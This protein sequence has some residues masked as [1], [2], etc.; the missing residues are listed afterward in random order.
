MRSE[1]FWAW[2]EEE[3]RPKLA[4]RR[5]T[6]AK[7]FEHLDGIDRPV[8][9]FETGCIEEPDNWA[10]N[11][12]STILF[13]RYI[14]ERGDGSRLFSVELIASK[15]EAAKAVVPNATMICGDSV[16][17]L[18]DAMRS[19]MTIDLLYLDA[20]HQYWDD[21]LP[22]AIHHH[23]ELMAAM[24]AIQRETMVVVDDSPARV[25]N[26][27]PRID[28]IGKG[29]LVAEHMML[30]GAE[31]AFCQYQA[32]WTNVTSLPA[33][34]GD[35]D[36]AALVERARRHVETNNP[37]A[38]ESLYRL[39]LG[40][41]TPPKSGQTRVAYGEACAFY[42][43]IALGRQRLGGAADWLREALS[44][45]PLGTDYRIDLV[46]RCFIPMGNL[47]T[48]RT[49][50]ERATKISPDHP[51]AWKILGNVHHELGNARDAIEAYDKQIALLPGDADAL[52][53]RATIA[54]DVEDY[55]KVRDCCALVMGAESERTPDATHCLA[56]VAY[57]E[58]R[59]EDA[60]A[61]FDQAIA[62]GCRDPGA[63]AWNKSLALHSI[64]RYIEGWAAHEEREHTRQNPALYLPMTRFT[65]P[66]WKGQPPAIERSTDIRAPQG[67]A[68]IHVHAEAG[69][70]DNLSLCRYLRPMVQL[71]YR[72]RYEA[73]DDMVDLIRGSFPEVEVMPRAADYPGALG[74]KPFDYH[75]PIGSL[76][77]VMKTDID[78]IPWDGPYLKADPI[79]TD[80]MRAQLAR[81]A[82]AS[83]PKV[84]FCWSSGI[85]PG[86]WMTEYGR[87]KSAAFEDIMP[88]ADVIQGELDG[89]AVALQVG[90]EREENG[91]YILDL[92]ASPKP[93]WSET[94]ALIANL[95]LVITVDT[96]VAHLAGGMGKPTWL[97]CQRDACSWHFMCWRPGA[98][99]NDRSPW[100]PTMRVFRQHAFDQPRF[101]DDVVADMATALKAEFSRA[102][103]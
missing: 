71:G 91:G 102:A 36:I 79:L 80:R 99:W 40:L 44:V 70:G 82:D 1:T 39:I 35:A 25:E 101:W 58:H 100:Y 103:A 43:Q 97:M 62:G 85:R 92:L 10:G 3:A 12:C 60:I 59:H 23:A 57:R 53:D 38:A 75:C 4:T 55:A 61:L 64:G 50:A 49:D 54:L 16:Q 56:M 66:R 93:S 2:Y 45:D 76:P 81:R 48:A 47:R 17:V 32:G 63:A 27:V 46:K 96:A 98:P 94:A 34:R 74:V 31:L 11:G 24:P 90:P 19:G 6:F 51:G 77:A 42:A 33:K 14:A 68:V 5:D 69:S 83:G 65:L 9:I 73:M 21:P 13:G 15:C 41:C 88:L 72:V 95:D 84:G 37:V 67:P 18:R 87:R 52:L 22:S 28:I 78:T 30:C 89:L 8:T 20:S 29:K 7:M 86:V 26:D